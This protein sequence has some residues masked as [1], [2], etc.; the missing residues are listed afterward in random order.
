[1]DTNNLP[2]C[3]TAQ[4]LDSQE[5][6]F[7]IKQELDSQESLFECLL[8]IESMIEMLLVSKTEELSCAQLFEYYRVISYS[9]LQAKQLSDDSICRLSKIVQQ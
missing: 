3:H 5:A 4:Q 2:D 1:M 7:L 9:V 8:G 6:P